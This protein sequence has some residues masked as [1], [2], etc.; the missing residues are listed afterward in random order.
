MNDYKNGLVINSLEKLDY[1]IKNNYLAECYVL[2]NGGLRSSKNI[3]INDDGIYEID[4]ESDDTTDKY[5]R[6]EMTDENNEVSIITAMKR[7]SLILYPYV[8]EHLKAAD[9]YDVF[10]EE[11][12]KLD[13]ISVGE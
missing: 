11:Y 9:E 6:E 1:V 7:N 5:T 3:S 13:K 8:L 10:I 4:N 2:L 12:S